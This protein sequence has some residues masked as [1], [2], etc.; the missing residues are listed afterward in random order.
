MESKFQKGHLR[1]VWQGLKTITDYK[2]L[3]AMPLDAIAHILHTVLS[4]LD[5]SKG[6]VLNYVRLQVDPGGSQVVKAGRHTSPYLTLNTGP[7][8]GCVLPLCCTLC[9]R[10]IVQ[11]PQT[12]NLYW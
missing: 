7:P 3:G 1:R 9:T 10:T 6:K 4:H 2:T 5:K 12:P 8:Q 11:P